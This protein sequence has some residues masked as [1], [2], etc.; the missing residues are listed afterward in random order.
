[1]SPVTQAL[2]ITL[3]GMS[4]VFLA[5]LALWGM[6]ALLVRVLPETAESGEEAEAEVEAGASDLELKQR[7]AA[8]AVAHALA[9]QS[10]A[11]SDQPTQFP[12]PATAIVSA[13]QAVNRS[14]IINRRG[15]V[16]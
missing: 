12:L 8:A 15:P 4:L 6:M 2:F 13:W 7:A 16:R 11:R 3:V 9:A 1:M 14:K 10:E 5:I